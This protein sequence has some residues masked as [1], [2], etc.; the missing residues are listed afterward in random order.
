LE[1]DTSLSTKPNRSHLDRLRQQ[2][3]KL[4]QNDLEVLGSSLFPSSDI[5]N[6]KEANPEQQVITT[7][8]VHQGD[9]PRLP[10]SCI[11]SLACVCM[12]AACPLLYDEKEMTWSAIHSNQ[13]FSRFRFH[14]G[15][16]NGE[17]VK[18]AVRSFTSLQMFHTHTHSITLHYI[19]L[20]SIALHCIASIH[21]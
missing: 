21:A 12:M 2:C 19:T 9:L 17:K 1:A 4:Q 8:Q 20:H 10:P 13:N 18:A 5:E 16:A 6:W 7:M 15:H 3:R 11:A 14:K